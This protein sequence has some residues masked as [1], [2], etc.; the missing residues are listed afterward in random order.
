MWM[1]NVKCTPGLWNNDTTKTM[2]TLVVYEFGVKCL[3]KSNAENMIQELKDK[4]EVE[5]NLEGNKLCGIN[6]R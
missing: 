6:L 3:S 5:I 1:H 4:Y 2:F